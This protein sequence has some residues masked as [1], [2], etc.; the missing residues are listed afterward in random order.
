MAAPS[1]P[2]LSRKTLRQPDEFITSVDWIGDWIARNLEP[3][4]LWPG[5]YRE[6]EQCIKNVLIRRDYRPARPP[7]GQL[8]HH[9]VR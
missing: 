4:Y 2:K 9:E 5:N 3:G 6:L 8:A 7:A 1:H